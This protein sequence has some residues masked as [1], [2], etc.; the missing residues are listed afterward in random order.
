VVNKQKNKNAYNFMQC[1]I[2]KD[3]GS[4]THRVNQNSVV[5]GGVVFLSGT[6]QNMLASLFERRAVG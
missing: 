1:Y 5:G 6:V 4:G 2:S 3:T